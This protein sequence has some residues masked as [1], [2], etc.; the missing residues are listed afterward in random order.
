MHRRSTSPRLLATSVD[1]LVGQRSRQ[2]TWSHGLAKPMHRRST[3]SHL[4]DEPVRSAAKRVSLPATVVTL[5][6]E[7]TRR[8]GKLVSLPATLVTTHH[9]RDS[10]KTTPRAGG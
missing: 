7:P 5:P 8:R 3:S 1:R 4:P 10:L 6:G 2:A 9:H